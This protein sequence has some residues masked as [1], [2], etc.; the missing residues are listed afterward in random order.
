MKASWMAW[1]MEPK[2]LAGT[3]LQKEPMKLDENDILMILKSV[4][5]Y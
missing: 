3:E 5:K 4:E 2:K 1:L